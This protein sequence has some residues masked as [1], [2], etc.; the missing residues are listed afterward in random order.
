MIPDWRGRYYNHHAFQA[1]KVRKCT[2]SQQVMERMP[3]EGSQ[4]KACNAGKH[5][6][7]AKRRRPQEAGA[8]A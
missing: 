3:R 6:F 5:W 1:A 2:L 7:F 8:E 4:W